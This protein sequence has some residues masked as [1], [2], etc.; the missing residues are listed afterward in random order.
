MKGHSAQLGG[1]P[2]PRVAGSTQAL[3]VAVTVLV[4]ALVSLI[5]PAEAVAALEP[6]VQEN[7]P[8]VTQHAARGGAVTIPGVECGTRC[9]DWWV[10]EH[11]PLPGQ[12]TSE[13]LH[14]G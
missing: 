13:Q 2:S 11:R 1:V 8:L 4:H 5:T 10:Q 6:V 14:R 3:V 7:M 9:A 12:P